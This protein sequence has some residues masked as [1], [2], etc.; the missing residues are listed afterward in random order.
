MRLIL[1]CFFSLN[2]RTRSLTWREEIL[3]RFS[4]LHPDL[5]ESER[6]PKDLPTLSQTNKQS[7]TENVAKAV[8]SDRTNVFTKHMTST[9]IQGDSVHRGGPILGFGTKR[10]EKSDGLRQTRDTSGKDGGNCFPGLNRRYIVS[11][12]R[13][14][15]DS[16]DLGQPKSG[17][18]GVDCKSLTYLGESTEDKTLQ[19]VEASKDR[20]LPK[21]AVRW[22]I[23]IRRQRANAA[24]EVAA[25]EVNFCKKRNSNENF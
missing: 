16:F 11:P 21:T 23:T 22:R 20:D 17:D 15:R 10:I 24:S 25:S 7:F 19:L 4:A 18:T 1:I 12:F 2:H 6:P 9:T 14:R 13:V 3:K 8:S 5:K